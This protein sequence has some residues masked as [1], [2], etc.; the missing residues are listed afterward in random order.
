M[1]FTKYIFYIITFNCIMYY[2]RERNVAFYWTVSDYTMRTDEHEI[3]A[4]LTG[5]VLDSAISSFILEVVAR[6]AEP[7][8]R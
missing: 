2:W 8:P 5:E 4:G 1:V 6:H 3:F 7:A